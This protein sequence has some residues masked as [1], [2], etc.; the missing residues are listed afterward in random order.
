MPFAPEHRAF[1]LQHHVT[2]GPLGQP[3]GG[4]GAEDVVLVGVRPDLLPWHV[5]NDFHRHIGTKA[6][7]SIVQAVVIPLFLA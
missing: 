1:H 3:V 6:Q 7:T 4:F 5:F 2:G